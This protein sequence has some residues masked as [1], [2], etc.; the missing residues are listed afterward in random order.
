MND[1]KYV[2]NKNNPWV[3]LILLYLLAFQCDNE[4]DNSSMGKEI[5]CLQSV[6]KQYS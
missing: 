6:I 2:V 4:N 1:G 5:L 3:S